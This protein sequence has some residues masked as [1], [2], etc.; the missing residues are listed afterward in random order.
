MQG[1]VDRFGGGVRMKPER[2]REAVAALAEAAV[3]L[4][5]VIDGDSDLEQDEPDA[6]HDGREPE[7]AHFFGSREA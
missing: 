3:N 7:G 6:E 5:D 1:C 4:L 2:I